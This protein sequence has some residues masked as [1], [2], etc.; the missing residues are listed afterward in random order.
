M[1]SVTKLTR[2]KLEPG[3][4]DNSLTVIEKGRISHKD[5]PR[6]IPSLSDSLSIGKYGLRKCCRCGNI[7]LQVGFIL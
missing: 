4:R 2:E 6:Y 3:D 5:R 1:L 7:S